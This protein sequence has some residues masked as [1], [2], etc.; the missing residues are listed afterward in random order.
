MRT[1][2][3]NNMFLTKDYVFFVEFKFHYK[4]CQQC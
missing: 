4:K 2:H 3:A 1:A